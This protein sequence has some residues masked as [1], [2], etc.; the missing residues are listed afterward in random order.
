MAAA[1]PN[2]NPNP[3]PNPHPN[4][5]PRSRP[6][7]NQVARASDGS[8]AR[9]RNLGAI[10]SVRAGARI[11]TPLLSAWLFEISRRGASGGGA[12]PYFIV[13]ALTAALIPVPLVLK[14]FE[15]RKRD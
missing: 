2:P 3:N 5:H 7:P 1:H 4:P 9:A 13:S 15:D 11:V 10:Y 8:E 6:H 14:S 12:L